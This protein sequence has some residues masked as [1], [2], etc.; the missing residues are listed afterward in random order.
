MA[1]HADWWNYGFR[2]PATYTHKQ[3]VLKEHCR[4]VGRDYAEI[5]QVIRAGILIA[6]SEQALKRLQAQPHVRPTG[7]GGIVG[8]PEQVTETLLGIIEQ[9]A[10]RF[11]V[12]FADSP[13]LEGTHLFAAMVLPQ[14][15]ASAPPTSADKH[16][17]EDNKEDQHRRRGQQ[18]DGGFGAITGEFA[19]F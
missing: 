12:H 4:A 6:E 19:V 10:D 13:R 18:I 14:L 2:D 15:T 16:A 3:T 1:E 5:A 11:T 9:G 8:T 17:L 7:E